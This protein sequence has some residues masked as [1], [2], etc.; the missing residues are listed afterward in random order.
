MRSSDYVQKSAKISHLHDWSRSPVAGTVAGAVA[1]TVA[2]T[3]D[4]KFDCAV[5]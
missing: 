1:G 5:T 4:S 2:G 3:A